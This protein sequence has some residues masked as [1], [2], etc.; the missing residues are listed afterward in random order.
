MA[1]I[2]GYNAEVMIVDDITEDSEDMSVLIAKQVR[3][4][5]KRHKSRLDVNRDEYDS[6]KLKQK[7]VRKRYHQVNK[8][9]RNS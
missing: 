8:L 7:Q 2:V 3:E 4:P 5:I 1:K 6:M 9:K